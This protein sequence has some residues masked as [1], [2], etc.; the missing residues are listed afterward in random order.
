[1]FQ[2]ELSILFEFPGDGDIVFV[3]AVGPFGAFPVGP[4][5]A[6]PVGSKRAFAVGSKRAFAVGSKRAFAVGP[7][8]AFPVGPFGAL[9]FQ[10]LRLRLQSRI[11]RL[12][13]PNV[14]VAQRPSSIFSA[15]IRKWIFRRNPLRQITRPF[16]GGLDNH[17][18]GHKGDYLSSRRN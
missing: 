10:I 6:F 3:Y 8:G 4:F 17:K 14:Y 5:G 2:P 18:R 13:D 11:R 9:S 16:F 1:M 7:F 12:G 15:K